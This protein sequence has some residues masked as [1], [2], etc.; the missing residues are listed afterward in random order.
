MSIQRIEKEIA[1]IRL[2]LYYK[3]VN[4]D[5]TGI[6]GSKDIFIFSQTDLFFDIRLMKRYGLTDMLS[7]R[8][9]HVSSAKTVRYTINLLFLI[10]DRFIKLMTSGDFYGAGKASSYLFFP[11]LRFFPALINER[12]NFIDR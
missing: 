12:N 3:G 7:K 4:R 1:A 6:V 9:Q 10:F 2:H 8:S 5:P 11:I